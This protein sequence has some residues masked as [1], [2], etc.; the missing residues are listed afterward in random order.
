MWVYLTVIAT[1]IILSTTILFRYA[2]ILMLYFI[3][4]IKYKPCYSK[5]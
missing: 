5:R 2:R 4:G 1:I 3:S